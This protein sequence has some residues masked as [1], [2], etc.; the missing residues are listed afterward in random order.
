MFVDR[1]IYE[2]NQFLSIWAAAGLCK[3]KQM[4][5]VKGQLRFVNLPLSEPS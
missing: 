2:N 4:G 5:A 1:F 3:L